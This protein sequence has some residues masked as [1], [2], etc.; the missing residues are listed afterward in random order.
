MM[1][2]L[3]A[4]DRARLVRL[5]G[6]LN[7]SF[8]AERET[9]GSLADRFIREHNLTWEQIVAHG[10]ESQH[11]Q[12][13]RPSTARSWHD[14]VVDCQQRPERLNQWERD[15]LASISTCRSGLTPKQKAKLDDIAERLRVKP[16]A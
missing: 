15:F 13:R 3:S 2:A 12:H 5:L 9:A 10:V 14:V 7:S 11:H 4:A 6:M 8:D 1:L 16:A